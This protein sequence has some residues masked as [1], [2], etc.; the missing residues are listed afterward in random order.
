MSDKLMKLMELID[1]HKESFGDG[2]YLDACNLLKEADKDIKGIPWRRTSGEGE[3]DEKDLDTPSARPLGI[4]DEAFP[5]DVF[6]NQIKMDDLI[7]YSSVNDD[8]KYTCLVYVIEPV[9][10]VFHN[11]T[12][13][14]RCR[15]HKPT[16]I[17]ISHQ[18]RLILKGTKLKKIIRDISTYGCVDTFTPEN[19]EMI[20]VHCALVRAIQE[21]DGLKDDKINIQYKSYLITK[22]VF[23]SLE[24]FQRFNNSN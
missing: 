14:I 10:Q 6:D 18:I 24:V 3:E 16:M 13:S 23:C 5:T 21:K 12:C 17:N 8:E 1:D 19:P 9:I 22:V 7:L 15:R 4:P 2:F 11:E 20:T